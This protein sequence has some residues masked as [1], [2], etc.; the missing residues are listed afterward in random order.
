MSVITRTLTTFALFHL[1][2]CMDIPAP[3]HLNLS[4][5]NFVHTLSWEKGTGSPD[6]VH[7][8]VKIRALSEGEVVVKECVN[9]TSPLR[10]DLTEA[11]SDVEETYYISVFAALGSQKSQETHYEAIKPILNTTFEAPL[12][13]VTAYNRSLNV[14]LSALD[15]R[16]HEIYDSH[17]FHYKLW[18]HSEDGAKFDVDIDGLGYGTIT[19]LAPGRR[20]CVNVTIIGHSTPPRPPVC[21]SIP[22]SP[23]TVNLSDVVVSVVLCLLMLLLLRFAPRLVTRCFCLK[24]LPAVLRSVVSVKKV[25][26][27]TAAEPINTVYEDRDF[28]Q[29]IKRNGEE[30]DVEE[31][32]EEAVKYERIVAQYLE[33]QGSSLIICPVSSSPDLLMIQSPDA[34]PSLTSST[35]AQS[36]IVFEDVRTTEPT[37][38]PQETSPLQSLSL[39]SST[40]VEDEESGTDVNLFSVKLGGVSAE[41]HKAEPDQILSIKVELGSYPQSL[42]QT[43][44]QSQTSIGKYIPE[45]DEE[46]EECSDYLSRN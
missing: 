15:E 44:S 19:D 1:A 6:G 25:L 5:H 41:P 34:D 37:G 39:V 12:L 4:S 21:A 33:G 43:D 10:C 26:L 3:V 31:E 46:D 9:V 16:L 14:S 45:G 18:V 23:E 27:I 32:T 7:Y 29:K 11:L 36:L 22:P 2:L 38:S 13:T 17:R 28:I 35:D 8:T 30:I 40:H 24:P 20:Y 42:L